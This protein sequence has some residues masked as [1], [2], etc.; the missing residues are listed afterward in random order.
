MW[1]ATWVGMWI[2]TWIGTGIDMDI[3]IGLGSVGAMSKPTAAAISLAR[4]RSVAD[5]PTPVAERA[6]KRSHQPCRHGLRRFEFG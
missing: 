1:I 4:R 3:V 2:A 5:A 6:Q